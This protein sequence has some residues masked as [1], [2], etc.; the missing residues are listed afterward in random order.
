MEIF[1]LTEPEFLLGELTSF[2][3]NVLSA[4]RLIA[5]F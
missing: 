1:K 3:G 5:A 2:S 4:D